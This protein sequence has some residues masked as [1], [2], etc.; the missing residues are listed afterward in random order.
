MKPPERHTAVS[1]T[2][3]IEE[4]ERMRERKRERDRLIHTDLDSIMSI[5]IFCDTGASS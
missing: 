5:F 1:L 2:L 3:V 4:R